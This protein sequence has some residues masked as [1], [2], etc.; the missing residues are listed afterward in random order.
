MPGSLPSPV[1]PLVGPGTFTLGQVYPGGSLAIVGN[2]IA[3]PT[4]V[5]T[6]CPHGLNTGD[7]I[8]WTASTASV[9]LLTVTPQQVVTVISPTTFS[10]PVNVTGGPGSAG[11]YDIAI[12][13]VPLTYPGVPAVFN[14]GSATGLRPGDTVTIVATGAVSA[15]GTIDG[16]NT[17]TAVSA[18]SRSFT[19]GA[20]TNVTTAGSATAGHYTKT[21][22]SS[23]IYDNRYG[24]VQGLITF[25]G[26][27]GTAPTTIKVDIQGSMD[28]NPFVNA[29]GTVQGNWYNVAYAATSAPQTLAVAE[30]TIA[31][32]TTTNYKITGPG[33]ANYLP[34]RFLR[35]NFNTS[36]NL[37]VTTTLSVLPFTS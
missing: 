17:V 12:L 30:L 23:D 19:V 28:Y 26:V 34:W 18:D 16:V 9:P 13:S 7:T 22:F 15:V 11:A 10:I 6:L 3:N 27:V 31:G 36:T 35:V 20:C 24:R 5:T 4:I 1:S 14:C 25:V 2:T 32:A 29:A 37:I 21:T 8:F 33:E